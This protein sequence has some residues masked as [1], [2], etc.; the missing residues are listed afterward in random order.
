MKHKQLVSISKGNRKLGCCHE[1]LND[2]RK[3]LC[4]RCP[5]RERWM[6][7]IE[8]AAALSRHPR[9]VVPERVSR[10]TSS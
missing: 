4:S 6:L 8:S 9:S 2:S 3:M 5:L 7:R 1:Y 10:Q